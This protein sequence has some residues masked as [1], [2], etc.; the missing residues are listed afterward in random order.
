MENILIIGAGPAGL[1]AAEALTT[2]GHRVAVLDAMA[3]PARK[4]LRAGIGG[5]N[6]T[7]S[8]PFE[9]VLARYGDRAATLEPFLREFGPDRI[10]QWAAGLGIETFIGS[11]G[12][13]FPTDFKAAPLLRAW[14]RRLAEQ[15]ARFYPRHRWL[16]WD[17]TGQHR[18]VTPEGELTF[19]AHAT[20]LALGGASWPRL[21]SNGAWTSA[22]PPATL[23]PFKPA[24]C[25]FNVAWSDH[26]RQ[27]Y[28]G[29]PVKSVGLSF[30][31]RRLKGE[32]VVTEHGIE[33]GAVYALSASLRDAIAR[34]GQAILELDLKPD[35]SAD[36]L[37]AALAKPRGS[38]SLANHL[39]RQAGIRGI[40]AGLARECL[41]AE[42]LSDAR[43]LKAVPVTLTAP[44]PLA[45]AISSAGGL[46]FDAVDTN[47]MLTGHPGTFIAGE[48]LDWEAPTG[49]YLL[50]ACFATGWACGQ[51]AAARLPPLQ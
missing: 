27:R 29:Q 14:L 49:G 15:G 10:R 35:W 41:A 3:S 12:R 42:R 40:I 7:H 21:G 37:T 28:A 44:R 1:M 36:K 26:F 46:R 2:A 19:S 13:I 32:F 31:G 47:L 9:A 6:L 38:R 18:F 16:G 51:A 8:E 4:F 5:L 43:A 20:I 30:V 22:F 11:S 17:E 48:M 45:E 24:N 25:G 23:A 34:D 33:G 39:E 50:T